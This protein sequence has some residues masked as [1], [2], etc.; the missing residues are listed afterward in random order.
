MKK[1]KR[2]TGKGLLK[3][4][5]K[6]KKKFPKDFKFATAKRQKQK[7]K[8]YTK[9]FKKRLK[10]KLKKKEEFAFSLLNLFPNPNKGIIPTQ[11]QV[12]KYMQ[13]LKQK[14]YY[15]KTPL[16]FIKKTIFKKRFTEFCNHPKVFYKVKKT[17]KGIYRTTI[18]KKCYEILIEKKFMP[19][20]LI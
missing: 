3:K 11:E 18:C 19:Y 12:K 10:N 2:I 13:M 1:K 14:K 4:N 9:K 20:D 6:I 8:D 7:N 16:Y 5:K 17:K 15:K